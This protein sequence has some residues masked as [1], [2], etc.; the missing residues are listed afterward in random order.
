MH[1]GIKVNVLA[2]HRASYPGST[3]ASRS[4]TEHRVLG[5]AS[6]SIYLIHPLVFYCVYW[7]LQPPLPP[8]WSE[9][10]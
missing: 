7:K 10:F 6:Y 1:E 2:N 9:E 4:R 5:D 8:I 3:R